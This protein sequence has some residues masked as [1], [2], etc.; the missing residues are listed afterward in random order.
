MVLAADFQANPLKK[1]D[2]GTI[3][4]NQ[5]KIVQNTVLKMKVYS[6]LNYMRIKICIQIPIRFDL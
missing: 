5:L 6:F 2:T 3:K 4:L 1:S